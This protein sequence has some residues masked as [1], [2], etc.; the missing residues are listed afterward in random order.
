[1]LTATWDNWS[2]ESEHFWATI[3]TLR[4]GDTALALNQTKTQINLKSFDVGVGDGERPGVTGYDVDKEMEC[5]LDYNVL[6][7]ASS[8]PQCS[9]G[10][11]KY[12][13]SGSKDYFWVSRGQKEEQAKTKEEDGDLTRIQV[14]TTEDRSLEQENVAPEGSGRIER[15][16]KEPK[17]NSASAVQRPGR[18][19]KGLTHTSPPCNVPG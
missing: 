8:D 11:L 16:E 15:E 12:T 13:Y 4:E 19:A 14:E 2:E 17:N 3:R 1:M 9:R 18:A 6:D 5:E 10:T 7:P